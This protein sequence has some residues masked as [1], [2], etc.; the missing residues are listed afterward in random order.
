MAGTRSMFSLV[1]MILDIRPMDS[2]V[3]VEVMTRPPTLKALSDDAVVAGIA[4]IALKVKFKFK[5]LS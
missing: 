4:N 3:L 5:I 2:L 1:L